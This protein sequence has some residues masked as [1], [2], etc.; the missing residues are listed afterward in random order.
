M[1]IKK[2][3]IFIIPSM[4][5]GGAE[6]VFTILLK[7]IDKSKFSPI[8]ILL[9][10]EGKYLEDIP[11]NIEVIDLNVTRTRYAFFKIIKTI[12]NIKPDIVFSTLGQLN[13]LIAIIRPL[14]SKNITFIARESS[15]VGMSKHSNSFDF[16]YK[17]VYNRFDTIIAQSEYMKIDLMKTYALEKSD[18]VVIN[19]PIDIDKIDRI[20]QKKDKTLFDKEKIN[21]VTAGRLKPVKGF[22]TLLKAMSK[23]E[24][25]FHLTILGEGDEENNLK[26]LAQELNIT[27]RISFLGFQGNPYSYMEEADLFILS[28]R[29]EGFPNVVLEAN[30]CGTPVV[31][32]DC[33]GGTGEIIE[34]GIN[35][36]LVECGNIDQL[37]NK[38]IQAIKYPWD[39]EKIINLIESK[40]D[41]RH[42]VKKYEEV[43]IK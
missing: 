13:L 3:I 11:K 8:L 30:A 43:L 39:K 27:G 24:S 15:I 2:K 32:F 7:Y 26:N 17:S 36:F 33:P 37:A 42:I 41:V 40:Y 29:Y 10:K 1:D 16:I 28:S 6:R 21:L 19:N 14:F 35:G 5:G 4:S 34:N 38:I 9:K 18:I 20:L 22:D 25:K 12:Y 23:L 31:A